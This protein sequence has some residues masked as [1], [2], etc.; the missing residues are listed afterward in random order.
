MNNHGNP[1]LQSLTLE[2]PPHVDFSVAA[3][4]VLVM[5]LFCLPAARNKIGNVYL[6]IFLVHYFARKIFFLSLYYLS[7]WESGLPQHWRHEHEGT[8]LNPPCR[9]SGTTLADSI[10][11]P[12][13][14]TV[15]PYNGDMNMKGQPWTTLQEP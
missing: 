5:V 9:S 12:P 4:Y 2:L 7:A 15:L 13:L 10:R 1:H 3:K 11:V 6:D 8:T 14:L